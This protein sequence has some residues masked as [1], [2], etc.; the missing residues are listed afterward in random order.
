MLLFIDNSSTQ[1]QHLSADQSPKTSAGQV[2]RTPEISSKL[3]SFFISQTHSHTH[4]HTM[5]DLFGVGGVW[6]TVT[7]N[8]VAKWIIVVLWISA[9][10]MDVLYSPSMKQRI[11]GVSRCCGCTERTT[12]SLKPELWTSL[13]TGSTRKEVCHTTRGKTGCSILPQYTVN[14]YR[15]WW[16]FDTKCFTSLTSCGRTMSLQHNGLSTHHYFQLS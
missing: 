10:T 13:C 16:A 14:S 6:G 7:C 8:A 12:R 3:F 11:M 15:V 5:D 4:T 2:L 9:G 1:L